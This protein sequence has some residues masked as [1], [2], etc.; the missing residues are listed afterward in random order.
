MDQLI[1]FAALTLAAGPAPVHKWV[2][3]GLDPA[4]PTPVNCR[5]REKERPR[6]VYL[7]A[8]DK[9]PPYFGR[10]LSHRSFSAVPSAGKAYDDLV[11]RFQD[12][13]PISASPGAGLASGSAARLSPEQTLFLRKGV[14]IGLQQ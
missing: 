4:A 7:L 1:D 11:K 3:R 5:A 9:G 2:T 12:V 8:S 6:D 13:L 14:E 10:F